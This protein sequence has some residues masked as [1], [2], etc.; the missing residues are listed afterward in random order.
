MK[1]EIPVIFSTDMVQAILAGRKTMTRRV[2]KPQPDPEGEITFMQNAPLDWQGEWHPWKWDT[3]QGE[4][5]SKDCPYGKVGDILFVRESWKMAMW[6]FNDSELTI[7]YADAEKIDYILPE[8]EGSIDTAYDWMVKQFQ[9]LLFKEIIAPESEEEECPMVFTGKKHPLSPSIHLPKW[10]SRIWLEVT[11]VRVE[12]L[13]NISPADACDEGIEY[14]NIDGDALEGGE[15]QA[16][17]K[18]YTWTEKKEEDP[19]YED[20][21]SPTFA[22]CV[23]SF[24]TLW[25]SINEEESWN[26]NPWVWVISFKVLSTNGRPTE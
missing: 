1:K 21:Y 7:E 15:L 22:S 13:H 23:D 19:N 16:D 4:S 3:E 8:S 24:R 25:Q 9:K 14:W 17:F 20:R 12:R 11:D 26:A 10:C 18:N 5:I 6:D 2:V